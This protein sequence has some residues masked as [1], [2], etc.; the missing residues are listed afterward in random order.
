MQVENL[1]EVLQWTAAFHQ[2][3]KE[4]LQDCSKENQDERAQMILVYLADHEG[5]LERILRGFST[6]AERNALNTYCYDYLEKHPILKHGHC[7]SPFKSLDTEHIMEKVV[8]QHEQVIALYEHL[9]SRVDIDSAKELVDAIR[10]VEENEIKRM[11][12][13]ANRF[14]DM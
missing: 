13:S 6:T 9:Y 7:G 4:C 3:L 5:S 10:D 2:N 14:S 12:Q 8:D 11:V 1:R